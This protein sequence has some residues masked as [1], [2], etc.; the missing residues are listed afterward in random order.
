MFIKDIKSKHSVQQEKMRDRK[1][2]QVIVD[3]NAI[4]YA[5]LFLHEKNNTYQWRK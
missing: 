5:F 4:N 3:E 2:I 1:A